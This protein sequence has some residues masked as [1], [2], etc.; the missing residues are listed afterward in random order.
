VKDNELSVT[1]LEPVGR[2]R[3]VITGDSTSGE[4]QIDIPFFASSTP[5]AK[6]AALPSVLGAGEIKDAKSEGLKAPMPPTEMVASR[7]L[8]RLRFGFA[9]APEIGEIAPRDVARCRRKRSDGQRRKRYQVL[10]T[11]EGKSS[12]KAATPFETISATS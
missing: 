6:Q 5:S 9:R 7:Q 12:F 11:G 8:N 3:F 10:I 2:M 1:F 4:G